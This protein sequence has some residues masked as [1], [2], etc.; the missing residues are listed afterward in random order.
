MKHDWRESWNIDCT[1]MI[2]TCKRCGAKVWIPKSHCHVHIPDED[3]EIMEKH[4]VEMDCDMQR[5]KEVH[6]S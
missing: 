6:E 3:P 4:K 1:T 2:F 5:V